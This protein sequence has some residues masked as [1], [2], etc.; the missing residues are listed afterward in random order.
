MEILLFSL[1]VALGIVV[2]WV[3]LR[4]DLSRLND[5]ELARSWTRATFWMAIVVFGP[6]C[7]PFHF[8]KTRRSVWGFVQGLL[9]LVVAVVAIGVIAGAL[10]W[11]LGVE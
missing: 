3:I 7:L 2:P 10:S 4:W 11:L 8:T 5:R 6:L 1:Q 9:A